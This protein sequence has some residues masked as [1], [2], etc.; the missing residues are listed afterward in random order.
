M[1]DIPAMVGFRVSLTIKPDLLGT[2]LAQEKVIMKPVRILKMVSH[3]AALLFAA[4]WLVATSSDQRPIPP[5]DCF[6]GVS[7][8]TTLS[9][10]L[11]TP[12]P[13]ADGGAVP[14]SCQGLDGLDSGASMAF[15]VSQ[16]LRPDSG[17]GCYGFKTESIEGVFDVSLGA[18]EPRDGDF[19]LTVADGEYSSSQLS[20]C[21]G[22]WSIS[23][24]PAIEPPSGQSVSP[25]T[26]SDTDRW[27]VGRVIDIDEATSCGAAFAQSG[28]LRCQDEF[29]VVSITQ[30][31]P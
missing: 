1:R 14:P 4:F 2:H 30:V 6:S 15:T 22:A 13:S 25:L 3:A 21:R 31:G 9:V 28:H 24:R 26:A 18:V 29:P 10:V 16:G 20:G 19:S 27:Y 5:R 11:G 8:P 12:A 7:N 23:L 17:G